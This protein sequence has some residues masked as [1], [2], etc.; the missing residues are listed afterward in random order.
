MGLAV[1]AVGTVKAVAMEVSHIAVRTVVWRLTA[2]FLG[3]WELELH[4]G[5]ESCRH[6]IDC[7][8]HN[9]HLIMDLLHIRRD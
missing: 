7:G 1:E 6:L 2:G 5:A 9:T 4:E 3:P 8:S